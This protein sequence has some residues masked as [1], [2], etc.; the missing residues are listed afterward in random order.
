MNLGY[1]PILMRTP[2]GQLNFKFCRSKSE[3]NKFLMVA[4]SSAMSININ[5]HSACLSKL[6]FLSA[7]L[8]TGA[9]SHYFNANQAVQISVG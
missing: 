5:V 2:A 1:L 9:V 4:G 3:I 7:G 8:E 6:P